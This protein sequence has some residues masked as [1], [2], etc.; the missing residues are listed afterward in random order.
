MVCLD[1]TVLI[2]EFRARGAPGAPV[3]R[4][5]LARGAE[6]LI[7]PAAAAGEF[8]DGA[9]MVSERRFQEAL[10]LLRQRRVVVADLETAGHYAEVASHLRRAKRPAARS[11]NDL[12]VA[13]T[14]RSHGARI[15]TRNPA[16]F[17]GI[18]GVEVSGY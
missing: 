13:A 6:V 14:A 5:L 9:A 3:N 7:V 11:P 10:A 15:L 12:W 2:D 1:T 17:E 8:L 18:P 4:A 16:G